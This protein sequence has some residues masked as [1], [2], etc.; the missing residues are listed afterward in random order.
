MYTRKSFDYEYPSEKEW[1]NEKEESPPAEGNIFST[2][3]AI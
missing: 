1:N 2:F 3:T